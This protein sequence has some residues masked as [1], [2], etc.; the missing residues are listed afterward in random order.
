LCK[1]FSFC[2]FL[3]RF[4]IILRLSLFFEFQSTDFKISFLF[5]ESFKSIDFLASKIKKSMFFEDVEFL[6]YS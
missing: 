2:F 6:P 1:I 3:L 4:K 5:F